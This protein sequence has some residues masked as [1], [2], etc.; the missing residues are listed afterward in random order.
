M[1]RNPKKAFFSKH[2]INLTVSCLSGINLTVTKNRQRELDC[3][4]ERNMSK[5]SYFYF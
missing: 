4:S 3:T 5:P 2:M 1:P